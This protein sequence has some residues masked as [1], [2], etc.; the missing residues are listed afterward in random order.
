MQQSSPKACDMTKRGLSELYWSNFSVTKAP[1]LMF[2]F[3]SKA[4]DVLPVL[5]YPEIITTS[6]VC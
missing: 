4:S 3:G 1:S 2:F 5:E 6:F